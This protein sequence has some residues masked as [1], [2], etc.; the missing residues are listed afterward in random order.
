MNSPP[1]PARS[2]GDGDAGR[3]ARGRVVLVISGLALAAVVYTGLGLRRGFDAGA[4]GPPTQATAIV[5]IAEGPIILSGFRSQ[6][7][8][9]FYLAGGTYRSDWSAWG[10]APE[11]P[12]CTHSI[13]L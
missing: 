1:R 11:Y 3:E 4:S 13:E 6:T 7:T 10:E 12:P 5:P 2:R 8:D 9:L